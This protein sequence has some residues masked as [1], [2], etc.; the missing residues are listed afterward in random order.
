MTRIS[1]RSSYTNSERTREGT[2]NSK[3]MHWQMQ[4]YIN[5]T[6]SAWNVPMCMLEVSS[7]SKNPPESEIL[8]KNMLTVRH[9]Q[10]EKEETWAN[11]NVL[12]KFTREM[13]S[14]SSSRKMW[15]SG[16][17]MNLS[18]TQLIC[19]PQQRWAQKTKTL[20]VEPS[21]RIWL[22]CSHAKSCNRIC[23]CTV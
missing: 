14:S 2:M 21:R 12:C 23:S 5:T 19:R 3:K 9:N 18:K 8:T 6:G 15:A 10:T 17:S 7:H 11:Q 4:N 20:R 22:L 13:N 1:R 16:S